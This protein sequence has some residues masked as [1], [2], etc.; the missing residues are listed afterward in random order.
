VDERKPRVEDT[1][2]ECAVTLDVT[3]AELDAA[4]RAP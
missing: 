4:L 2:I 1:A 3:R